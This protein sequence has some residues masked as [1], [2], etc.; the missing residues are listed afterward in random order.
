MKNRKST[1]NEPGSLARKRRKKHRPLSFSAMETGDMQMLEMLRAK[2][3]DLA[4]DR[5]LN[6]MTLLRTAVFQGRD[7]VV[8][9]LRETAG[10]LDAYEAA[11]LGETERLAELFDAGEAKLD[12]EAPEGYGLLHLCGFFGCRETA[13]M[14]LDRG[15]RIGAVASNQLAVQP[16][17]SAAAGRKHEMALW[18][19]DRGADLAATQAGGW[20]LLHHAAQQGAL[21]FAEA[22]LARS[23]DPSVR[24]EKGQ[25]PED[26]ARALGHAEL[27]E[28]LAPKV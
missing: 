18:L 9:L 15:A 7:E 13:E 25:S 8:A 22:L 23:A 28:R 11:V 21:E 4:H 20:T 12:D 17:A 19:L 26:I 16:V 6:K 2:N 1:S 14:L 24:N 3:P 5:D 10:P 27:A